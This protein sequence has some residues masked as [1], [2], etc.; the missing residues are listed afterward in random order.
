MKILKSLLGMKNESGQ[1]LVEFALVVPVLLLFILGILE[2][3]WLLNAKITLT[4]GAREGAR[5]AVV[6][7][8][9]R[10]TRAFE[11]A[12]ES[13]EGVSGITLINDSDHYKYYEVEDTVNNVRNAVVEI[14]GNVK[15][16]IG[17]FVNDP[18]QINAKAVMR[19]E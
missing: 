8:V 7:T 9:N 13:V 14:K 10:N 12:R 17:M 6:S 15:P 19:I 4:G 1:S 3:G 18:F 11:A 2:F 5:A 16:L